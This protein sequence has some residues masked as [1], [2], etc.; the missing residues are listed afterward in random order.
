VLFDSD[1]AQLYGVAT[2]NLNKAVKRNRRR[3]PE[4]FMFQLTPEEV[5]NLRFQIGISS[6]SYGGRR[7]RPHALTEQAVALLSSVLNSR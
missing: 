2:G 7:Y 4:D 3:F 6:S 1:L 5:A